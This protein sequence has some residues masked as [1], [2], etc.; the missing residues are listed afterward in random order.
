M[1]SLPQSIYNRIMLFNS[2]P[3][4]DIIRECIVDTGE[5]RFIHRGRAEW[6]IGD[7][8]YDGADDYEVYV[9]TKCLK[10]KYQVKYLSRIPSLDTYYKHFNR[11][12]ISK[13]VTRDLLLMYVEDDLRQ[14][15]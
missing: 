14:C 2:H 3:T 4:A 12:I 10:H 6:L 8:D 1:I 15:R 7:T 11:E 13:A 9:I 5:E